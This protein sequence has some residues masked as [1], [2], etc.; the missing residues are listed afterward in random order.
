MINEN[1]GREFVLERYFNAIQKHDYSY[2]FADDDRSWR[3]G[4]A[5]EDEIKQFIHS[6]IDVCRED[7]E[8][9]LEDSLYEVTEQYTDGL[10]HRVIRSWFTDYVENVEN[11]FVKPTFQSD[12]NE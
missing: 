9:L 5:S 2:M 12:T 3:A 7:A 4:V 1:I 8:K 10:T 11:I 6:L